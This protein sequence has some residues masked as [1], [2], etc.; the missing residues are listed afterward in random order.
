MLNFY[1]NA[2][3]IWIIVSAG[4]SSCCLPDLPGLAN[5]F[6]LLKNYRKSPKNFTGN[7]VVCTVTDMQ[8]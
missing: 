6:S 2:M 3:H 4:V 7:P 8:D 5:I 1:I